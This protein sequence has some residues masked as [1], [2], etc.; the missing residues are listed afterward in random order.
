MQIIAAADGRS[1]INFFLENILAM[2][3]KTALLASS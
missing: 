2:Q 1:S 3:I